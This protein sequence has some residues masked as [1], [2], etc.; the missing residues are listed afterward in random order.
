LASLRDRDGTEVSHGTHAG[1]WM[2]GDHINSIQT[3]A[4][5]NQRLLYPGNT[6]YISVPSQKQLPPYAR[7]QAPLNAS[8]KV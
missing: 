4:D 8:A 6:L 7:I 3:S 5:R 2:R 1:H